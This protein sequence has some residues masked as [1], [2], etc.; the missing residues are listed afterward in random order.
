MRGGGG[1]DVT[2]HPEVSKGDIGHW[3]DDDPHKDGHHP[4]GRRTYMMR[5]SDAPSPSLLVLYGLG[6]VEEEQCIKN[7]Q[8]Q[9][10]ERILL[11]S[12]RKLY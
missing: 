7:H 10:T 12:V 2:C 4:P 3:C 11:K 8:A 6:G 9:R 5:R 1:Q